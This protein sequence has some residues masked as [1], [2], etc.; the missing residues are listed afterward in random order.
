MENK[1]F[2]DEFSKTKELKN[3]EINNIC[4]LVDRAQRGERGENG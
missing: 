4:Y 2:S 3:Q 1:R